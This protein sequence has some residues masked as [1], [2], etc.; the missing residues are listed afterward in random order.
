MWRVGVWAPNALGPR[1]CPL[2]GPLKVVPLVAESRI[3]ARPAM[4]WPPSST[5]GSPVTTTPPYGEDMYTAGDLVGTARGRRLCYELAQRST[6]GDEVSGAMFYEAH[7]VHE[8]RRDLSHGTVVPRAQDAPRRTWLRLPRHRSCCAAPVRSRDVVRARCPPDRRPCTCPH[9]KE[10]WW[11]PGC[12]P[13]N[14]AAEPW[15]AAPGF[16]D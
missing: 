1:T 4:S 8:E 13:Y 2:A 7:L 3:R 10:A 5:A 15:P 11:C 6:N 16:E 12:Q 9:H 14:S